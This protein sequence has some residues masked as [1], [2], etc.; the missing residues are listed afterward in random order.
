MSLVERGKAAWEWFRRTRIGRMNDRYNLTNGALLAGGV[1]YAGLFSVFAILAIAFSVFI[2]LL[3][4]HAALREAVVNA[5]HD[6]LPGVIDIGDGSGGLLTPDDLVLSRSLTLT[7]VVAAVTLLFSGLAVMG[8]LGTAVRAMFGL[9]EPTGSA[10]ITKLRDFS[11]FVV[12]AL[13]VLT[14]ATLTVVAGTAGAWMTEQLGMKPGVAAV[15][16]RAGTLLGAF[17]VDTVVFAAIMRFL[18]GAR[19][20]WRDLWF[21]A[22]IGA[23][24]AGA[25]RLLGT[26]IVGGERDNPLLASFA[27]I[28]TLLLWINLMA[29]IM[30]YVS[31]W[32][33]NPPPPKPLD[34]TPAEIHARAHPNYVTLS[35]PATLRWDH[36]PRT[37]AILPSEAHRPEREA[38]EAAARQHQL[39][40]SAALDAALQQPDSWRG[41]RRALR[42]ARKAAREA[43]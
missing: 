37:G 15:L 26:S 18:G 8:Q 32:T 24:L 35:V 38:E 29:R 42:A 9:I 17:A 34:V 20:P 6:A 22:M 3:G 28:V 12:L 39:E 7:S 21:G 33:A 13:A 4:D 19:P 11:G 43:R 23:G 10:V 2:G 25:L 41:R 14:T 16:V 27:A 1:A 36:D 30:L 40:L 31:A 5:M